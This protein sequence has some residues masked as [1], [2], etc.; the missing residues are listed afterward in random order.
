[1]TLDCG[2][3]ETRTKLEYGIY[4]LTMGEGEEG[5]ALAVSWLTQVS[6]KPSC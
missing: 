3:S 1:M 6:G 5:N 4:V 2:V